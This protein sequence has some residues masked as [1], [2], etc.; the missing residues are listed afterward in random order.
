MSVSAASVVLDRSKVHEMWRSE[1]KAA[2]TETAA[3]DVVRLSSSSLLWFCDFVCFCVLQ[4]YLIYTSGSTGVPKGVIVEHRGLYNML[5]A[6]QRH[7]KIEQQDRLAWLFV[8][9]GCFL[10]YLHC[11][12]VILF[13]LAL[14]ISTVLDLT[15]VLQT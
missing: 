3:E 1:D 12:F 5:A 14:F 2:L 15:A 9:F 10:V 6:V 11:L 13:C 7:A 8:V 4:A